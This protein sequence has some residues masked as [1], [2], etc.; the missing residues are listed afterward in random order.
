MTLMSLRDAPG[1]QREYETIFILAPDSDSDQIKQINER[2]RGVV[3]DGKGRL[4]RVE[5]WGKRKLAFE[6][7]KHARGI[8]LY[9]RYLSPPPLVAEIE[10]NLRMLDPVIRYMTVKIDDSVDPNARPSDMD[11][12]AFAAAATTIPD[13]EDIALGRVHDSDSSS[14]SSE[15]QPSAEAGAAAAAPEQQAGATEAAGEA[16]ASSEASGEAEASPKTEESATAEESAKAGEAEESA[17]PA[18]ADEKK[19][20]EGE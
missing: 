20:T 11:E 13:E 6:I 8:Y 16:Q 19:E 9:W 1:S 14:S 7:R 15:G 17:T 12:E 5:N 18:A 4:L 2:V 3:E 10:R